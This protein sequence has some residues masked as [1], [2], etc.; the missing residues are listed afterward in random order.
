MATTLLLQSILDSL[1][2]QVG[3]LNP[4]EKVWESIKVKHVGVERVRE[5]RL[6]MLMAEFDRLTM[7]ESKNIEESKLVKKFIKSIPR[8]EYI[9]IYIVASLEHVLD[10]KTTS[11]E[12][13]V[14]RLKVY[15]ELIYD[16]EESHEDQCKLM[17]TSAIRET[18]QTKDLMETT[19]ENDVEVKTFL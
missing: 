11:Y 4:A 8:K 2:L 12:D 13:I 7:K 9:Y 16:E 19:K 10:L 18:I 5:A 14:E 6:Q 1:G 15:E 17:F 3:E